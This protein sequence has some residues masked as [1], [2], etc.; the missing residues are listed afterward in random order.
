MNRYSIAEA[1]FQR[2]R[3]RMNHA[4]QTDLQRSSD[5][6]QALAEYKRASDCLN[7][8]LRY[9]SDCYSEEHSA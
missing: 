8:W 9:C 2:W 3:D 5:A 1:W 7:A 4:I 6:P